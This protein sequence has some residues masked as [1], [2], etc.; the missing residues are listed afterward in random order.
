MNDNYIPM[1]HTG[2]GIVA[3]GE[4]QVV[5][6]IESQELVVAAVTE[7]TSRHAADDAIDH[8]AATLRQ[9]QVPLM[10]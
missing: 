3:A 4:E 2:A 8:T 7:F 10:T 5:C 6:P 1:L 9:A